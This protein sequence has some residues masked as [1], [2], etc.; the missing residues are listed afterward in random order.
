ML[1]A[2]GPTDATIHGHKNLVVLALY[3]TISTCMFSSLFSNT[4]YVTSLENL[5][6]DQYISCLVIIFFI[7]MTCIF[8]QLVI[9]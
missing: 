3:A 8:D 7:L 9:V 6:K 2:E 1:F 4:S 5:V